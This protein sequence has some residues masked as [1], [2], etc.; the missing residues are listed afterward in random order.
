MATQIPKLITNTEPYF[1]YEGEA[2]ATTQDQ[3]QGFLKNEHSVLA[4]LVKSIWQPTTAYEIG[5]IITSPNMPKGFHAVAQS[6]G[7]TGANEPNWGNGTSNVS[8][9]T[10]NWKMSKGDITVNG[11]SA[12]SK[13]NIQINNIANATHATNA[14]KATKATNADN[15]TK[16]TQDSTGQTINSTYIKNITIENGVVTITKGNGTKS[17]DTDNITV[18]GS[19]LP[20][21]TF[22]GTSTG[23]IDVTDGSG[24]ISN[25]ESKTVRAIK[26]GTYSLQS[27]LQNLVNNSHKH[28]TYR[29]NSN[30]V[31]DCNC[32]CGDTDS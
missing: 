32:D 6:K 15:A 10:I 30:C 4:V 22:R 13:G 14:D 8:D 12:D 28:A 31:C 19:N 20:E 23:G 7:S 24:N 29:E 25:Y 16:A 18:T 11:V 17:T 27:L 1:R 2:N 5:D 9:G 26:S 21:R 3:F